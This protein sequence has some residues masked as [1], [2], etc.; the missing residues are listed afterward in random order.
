MTLASSTIVA[1]EATDDD[2]GAIAALQETIAAQR[3]AFRADPY[4]SLERRVAH[5]RA[6]AGML[7]GNRARIRAAVDEDFG[8]HPARFTDL[9]EI[10]APAGRAAIAIEELAGWMAEEER[11]IDPGMY[12]TGRASMRYEPKGVVGN[13]APWNFP[14]EIACGPVVEMLAAGNR[15]VIKPSDLAPASASLLAELVAETFDPDHVAVSVGGLELARAFARQPWDHLMYTGSPGVGREVMRAAAEHLVPVT[16][17]LGGKCPAV[18]T[19]S[20][21]GAAAAEAILGTKLI[22][23]GQMCISVDHVL[24]P[25]DRL[26]ELVELLVDTAAARVPGH[27]GTDDCVGMISERHRERIEALL[28][29][30]RDAGTRIVD[31]EPGAA[32]DGRRLPLSLVIDPDPS[33]RLSREELFGPILPLVPYDDLGEA[34]A[35]I[36]ATDRPLGLYV[37]G[38]DPAECEAIVRAARSGGA[39]INACALQGALPTLGFGGSGTSGMGRHHGI[40]G[41]REFSTARGVVVRGRDDAIDLLYPPYDERLGAVVDAAFAG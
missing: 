1:R 22:K 11:A 24:V 7:V 13:M 27:S 25:R 5:L 9:I 21:V 2:A 12:G 23:N 14:F 39:C 31:L 35:A 37:F 6:L 38:E 3:A 19:P 41:F 15:V 32:R 40:E 26:E 18:L 17:E 28:R 30:A 33:L 34:V 10:L 8:G 29:E 16:L 36:D 20:G 4:P